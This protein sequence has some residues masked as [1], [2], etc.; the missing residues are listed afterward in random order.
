MPEVDA[1]GDHTDPCDRTPRER[2]PDP[3]RSPDPERSDDQQGREGE[4]E[5]AAVEV[6]GVTGTEREQT[7]ED[8]H[9]PHRD[10]RPGEPLDPRPNP[11]RRHQHRPEG[12]DERLE[13]PGVCPHVGTLDGIGREHDRHHDRRGEDPRDGEHADTRAGASEHRGHTREQERPQQVELLLD[14]QRPRVL[15]WTLEARVREVA[16][17]VDEPPVRHIGDRRK[18]VTPERCPFR[19][20]G[21][22]P[23]HERHDEQQ[24]GERRQQASS[25]SG[26][27]CPERDAAGPL[28]L[29]DQQRRD[30]EPGEHEEHVHAQV[31]GPEPRHSDV[32]QHDQ[33]D[34]D[35]AHAIEGYD[36]PH[37][38]GLAPWDV[39]KSAHSGLS[40]SH[41]TRSRGD[42]DRTGPGW[43]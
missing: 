3:S 38:A 13:Q 16:A 33:D 1:V 21:D 32:E 2:A 5:R 10:H 19:E 36:V 4:G 37:G 17:G 27:E 24:Q 12:A 43:S 30:Q 28:H 6:G 40:R 34:R 31:S 9:E 25:T 14:R 35:G 39:G 7:R 18:E 22:E 29:A 42:V 15:Q 41:T 11:R 20:R 8:A 26:P 23:R